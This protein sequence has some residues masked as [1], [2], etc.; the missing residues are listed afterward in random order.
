MGAQIGGLFGPG[1][2]IGGAI[3]SAL[4][5]VLGGAA[6]S[7]VG[8][9]LGILTGSLFGGGAS[10]EQ[11][12]YAQRASLSLQ[13]LGGVEGLLQGQT[14][15]TA[16]DFGSDNGALRLELWKSLQLEDW[17]D[18]ARDM[19]RDALQLQIGVT[20]DQAAAIVHT[21]LGTLSAGEVLTPET[22][23]RLGSVGVQPTSAIPPSGVFSGSTSGTAG[24]YS[25]DS[26]YQP[27]NVITAPPTSRTIDLNA[28]R[29]PSDPYFGSGSWAGQFRT[30]SGWMDNAA[31]VQAILAQAAVFN[32]LSP[33][34]SRLGITQTLA[35]KLWQGGQYEVPLFER[36]GWVPGPVGRPQVAVVHGGEYVQPVGGAVGTGMT[37]VNNFYLQGGDR[38]MID[39]IRREVLPELEERVERGFRRRARFGQTEID[40]R[41]IRTT[42]Q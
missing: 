37:L 6:G 35:A 31:A 40:N 15:G 2:A 11:R 38:Q 14:L 1:G 20:R 17:G 39:L 33:V 10:R 3:G 12:D 25:G 22:L 19:L 30:V 42:L 34:G 5:Q 21:M 9:F 29:T 24:D 27:T 26:S 16:L 8:A 7:A 4:G 13:A 32:A 23:T 36:G 41:V 28:L 18:L